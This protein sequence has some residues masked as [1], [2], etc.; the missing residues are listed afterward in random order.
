MRSGIEVNDTKLKFRSHKI[1]S[2]IGDDENQIWMFARKTKMI[3]LAVNCSA[4]ATESARCNTRWR[5]ES[6]EEFRA[7]KYLMKFS[8]ILD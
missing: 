7:V 6:L 2:E 3:A 1:I 4:T 5:H 8:H